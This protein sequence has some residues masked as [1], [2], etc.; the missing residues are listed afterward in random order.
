LRL[1][2]GGLIPALFLAEEKILRY[3]G[4]EWAFMNTKTPPLSSPLKGG[5]KRRSHEGEGA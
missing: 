1:L 4:A 5:N 3:G 2:R